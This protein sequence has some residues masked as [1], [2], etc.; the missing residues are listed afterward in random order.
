MTRGKIYVLLKN[1]KAMETNEFNGDMYKGG[2]YELVVS[3]LRR[4]AGKVAFETAVKE[5]NKRTFK[6]D[7]KDLFFY[8]DDMKNE[9]CNVNGEIEFNDKIY[10]DKFF[11]DY[12]FFKNCSGKDITF[13]CNMDSTSKKERFK[14]E[15]GKI[16]TFH[17]GELKEVI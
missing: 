10:F 12:L 7:E 16:V 11:S 8:I 9:Y 4:V 2:H 6:Y 3:K 17:F 1:N 5:F 14:L 13:K 15:N